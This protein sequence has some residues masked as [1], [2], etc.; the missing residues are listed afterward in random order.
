[1]ANHE[2]S[3]SDT[4]LTRAYPQGVEDGW[5]ECGDYEQP[6]AGEAIF[7]PGA[8]GVERPVVDSALARHALRAKKQQIEAFGIK[9]RGHRDQ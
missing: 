6:Q 4:D 9:G 2:T 1:M 7:V 3:R 8:D 5:L